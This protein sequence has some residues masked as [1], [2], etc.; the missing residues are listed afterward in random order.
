M[1]L[2]AA[3]AKAPAA[4]DTGGRNLSTEQ[5]KRLIL[6][7]FAEVF[8]HR[9]VSAVD[10]IYAPDVVAHSAFPDQA[11][12]KEGIK[13]AIGG[14]FGMFDDLEVAVEDIIAEKDRVV[15]RERWKGRYKTSGKGAEGSVVH[16]FRIR[17]GKISDEW[18]SG[19][20]WLE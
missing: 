16:I 12:G 11:P 17:D 3:S 13:A 2:W 5:N 19:W 1:L 14:F 15:T 4:A 18:S 7:L 6:R 9:T 20:D 10:E 8:N